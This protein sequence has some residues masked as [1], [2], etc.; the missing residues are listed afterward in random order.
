MSKTNERARYSTA[1]K[2]L[3]TKENL[4]EKHMQ[5][6]FKLAP[7]FYYTLFG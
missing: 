7:F 5:L 3:K 4:K 1:E 2:V 6:S